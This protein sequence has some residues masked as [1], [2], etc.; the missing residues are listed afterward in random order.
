MRHFPK[1][2]VLVSRCL[3]FGNVRHD[4]HGVRSE[5]VRDMM[6]FADLI[7]VCPEVEIGLG[8]PRD[9]LRLVRVDDEDRLIMPS[10]GEDL[11]DRMLY[12]TK[13]FLDDLGNI[14]GFIF[15]G[16]SPSMG[17]DDA[18]VYA[19][20]GP[21]PV[22]KRTAGLFAGRVIKRYPGYPI[23]ENDR[24]RNRRIR[25]HFLTYLYVFTA[26]RQVKTEGSMEA[27]MAFHKN[28]RFLFISYDS[29]IA[30][31]MT[32]LQDPDKDNSLAFTEYEAL[33]KQLMRRPGQIDHKVNAARDMF[34]MLA[35]I[36]QEE[37]SFFED[38]LGRYI[39]NSISEDSIIEVLRMLAFR[40]QGEGSYNNSFLYPYPEELKGK[41]DEIRDKEYWDK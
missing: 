8:V 22:V 15:K 11:T 30:T 5:I 38:M 9:T 10:T 33:L 41:V 19:K 29:S 18:K 27:L 35:D 1:P 17:M 7:H 34:S 6:P 39:S 21:S 37:I 12:F 3:E 28:N 20:T 26:F 40:S 14:D 24:L 31:E 16:H 23:E 13:D 36:T 4:G 32:L 2:T 25:H